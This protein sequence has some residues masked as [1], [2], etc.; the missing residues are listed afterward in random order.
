MNKLVSIKNMPQ[1]RVFPFVRILCQRITVY[2][3]INPGMLGACPTRNVLL[4]F[5]KLLWMDGTRIH[6]ILPSFGWLY[7]WDWVSCW[8]WDPFFSGS[9]QNE[10]N[11]FLLLLLFVGKFNFLFSSLSSSLSSIYPS[12]VN[13]NYSMIHVSVRLCRWKVS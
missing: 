10:L 2:K 7:V 3:F 4:N 1:R 12:H 11:S 5:A 6:S 13:M 9:H 8:F